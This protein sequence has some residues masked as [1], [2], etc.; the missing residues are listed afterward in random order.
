MKTPTRE[1]IVLALMAASTADAQQYQDAPLALRAAALAVRERLPR[2]PIAVDPRGVMPRDSYRNTIAPQIFHDSLSL[3]VMQQ[4]LGGRIA[5]SDSLV[6]CQADNPA[7]C[8]LRD[9][10]AIV[11]FEQPVI[12]GDTATVSTYST[13]AGQPGMPLVRLDLTMTLVKVGGAWG[14]VGVRVDRP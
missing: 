14:V 12:S 7:N 9:V 11:A 6:V 13:S 5:L 4:L 10:V 2:G 1:V 8:R 3:L